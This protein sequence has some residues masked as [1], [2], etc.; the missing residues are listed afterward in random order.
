M[1][2]ASRAVKSGF[3]QFYVLDKRFLMKNKS[4][5]LLALASALL[6]VNGAMAA[7]LQVP[8]QATAGVVPPNVMFTL[9]DSGSMGFECLPD[10][11]CIGGNRV[12]TMPDS[13]GSWKNGVA[14][15][16]KVI[17]A[18]NQGECVSRRSNGE[19]KEYG[20]DVVTTTPSPQIFGRKLRSAAVNPLYYNPA[21][22]YSAWLKADGTRYPEYSG[23]VARDF[24]E[25]SGSTAVRNLVASQSISTTWCTGPSSCTLENQDVYLAQYFNLTGADVNAVGSYTQVKI[26]TG[27]VYPKVAARTDCTVSTGVCSYVEELKNFSNWYSYHR[28]RI[29]VA[30]AGTAEAFY[31][32]PGTYRVGYGRINKA[33]AAS[34]DGSPNLTTI[35]KGV[36]PFLDVTGGNKGSF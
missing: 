4:L 7:M 16:D 15:Y 33:T 30:I 6:V 23:T 19:C 28:S 22:R 18:T 13:F 9:D 36:R 14:T 32:V 27:T 2:T 12:G 25:T 3:N 35:E 5:I 8:I 31:S 34:V 26:Q 17:T 24:P 10:D 20:P 21:V 29:R 11:L 1:E